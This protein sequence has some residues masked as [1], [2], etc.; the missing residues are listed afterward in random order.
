MCR[1]SWGAVPPP[2]FGLP[3]DDTSK[4]TDLR[5]SKDWAGSWVVP[6]CP[7]HRAMML[8]GGR[9]DDVRQLSSEDMERLETACLG[10]RETG[11]VDC[12]GNVIVRELYATS[13]GHLEN[14]LAYEEIRDSGR[15]GRKEWKGGVDV[16]RNQIAQ[17]QAACDAAREELHAKHRGAPKQAALV[18]AYLQRLRD[19]PIRLAFD[20]GQSGHRYHRLVGASPL[21]GGGALW[22][23]GCSPA[24]HASYHRC[25]VAEAQGAVL[26][27][28]LV[29][30]RLRRRPPAWWAARTLAFVPHHWWWYPRCN[31]LLAGLVCG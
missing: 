17:R 16:K 11:I 28:L 9:G 5:W 7:A 1:Q 18:D 15:N 27:L 25:L 20:Q 26:A 30:G 19:Y 24:L 23:P 21:A 14:R 10:E 8:R 22:V 29:Q 31:N 6:D 2:G 12:T 4:C 13:L 3:A